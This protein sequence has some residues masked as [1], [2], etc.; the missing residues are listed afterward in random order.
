MP[1]TAP[2]GRHGRLMGRTIAFIRTG[3]DDAWALFVVDED[4]ETP[5]RLLV[6]G[7]AENTAWS[8]DGSTIA[9]AASRSISVRL[10]RAAWSR[11]VQSS[12]GFPTAVADGFWPD[13]TP[14]GDLIFEAF[15][16]KRQAERSLLWK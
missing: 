6:L 12:G 16:A 3:W 11:T 15:A 7:T 9:F 14:T 4:G 1:H 2:D 13:W 10:R 5:P 8:P